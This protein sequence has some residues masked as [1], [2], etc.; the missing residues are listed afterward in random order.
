LHKFINGVA[1]TAHSRTLR[2]LFALVRGLC[3]VTEEWAFQSM[4]QEAWA[5][6]R[7]YLHLRY[8]GDAS[9]GSRGDM[10]RG[11]TICVLDSANPPTDVLI[12]LIRAAGAK[13]STNPSD[14]GVALVVFG[15][16]LFT[17]SLVSKSFFSAAHP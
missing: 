12:E 3:I 4:K 7:N 14:L 17:A 6:V 1:F 15:K 11:K 16:S 5:D 8:S 13:I 2:T 10:F 9:Q